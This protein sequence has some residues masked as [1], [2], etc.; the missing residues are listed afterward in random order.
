MHERMRLLTCLLLCAI[1]AGVA[2]DGRGGAS[3]KRP[4]SA[5][6]K[7]VEEAELTVKVART[8]LIFMQRVHEIIDP[9]MENAKVMTSCPAANGRFLAQ[10]S[11]RKNDYLEK[12]RLLNQLLD[13]K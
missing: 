9:D 12:V 3:D 2:A 5:S 10:Y 7:K 4:Q 8:E 6:E 11:K 13:K 1:G